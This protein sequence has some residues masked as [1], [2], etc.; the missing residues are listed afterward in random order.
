[1]GWCQIMKEVWLLGEIRSVMF[2]V[3]LFLGREY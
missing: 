3:G 2:R 1:M